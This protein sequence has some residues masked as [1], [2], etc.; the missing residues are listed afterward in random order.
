MVLLAGFASLL[1]QESGQ[2]DMVIGTPVRGRPAV[3]LEPVMGFFVN[4]L[5]LRLRVDPA[6]SFLALL[7]QVRNVALDAFAAP[8]APLEQ[9]LHFAGVPRSESHSPIY[10]AFFSYQDA[11]RRN[12]AWGNLKQENLR[13]YPPAAA[14]D[15][16]LWFM[17]EPDG[18]L[19]GLTYNTDV[20][21][22]PRVA[23]WVRTYL[24][25]LAGAMASPD[26]PLRTSAQ[27]AAPQSLATATAAQPTISTVTAA[28]EPI[29]PNPTEA[30]LV[31]IWCE[32]LSLDHV[33]RQDNFFDLGGHSL[34]VMQAIA[35]M[36]NLTGKALSPRAYVLE[37]LAQIATRYDTLP[38][39]ALPRPGLM[40]RLFGGIDK[41]A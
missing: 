16:R 12:H 40:K 2:T 14:E 7:Q 5:P 29:A 19:G 21:D 34:L 8:D 33:D 20:F 27:P 17:V 35:R 24:S 22:A 32:L 1:W 4:A 41:N 25:L 23:R 31:R 37:T 28:P 3:D 15:V 10:Q 9:M 11:R 30:T 18:V 36:R 38:D 39:A 6:Q 26:A 13:V